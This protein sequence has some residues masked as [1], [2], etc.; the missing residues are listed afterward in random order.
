MYIYLTTNTIN[1]KKYIGMCTRDDD[2]YFGSGKLIKSAIKKYGKENFSKSILEECSSLEELSL[3][4]IKWIN[5]YD[6]VNSD[7]FYNLSLGGYGGNPETVKAYWDSLTK[8]ERS[9]RNKHQRGWNVKGE[10]NPMY[11][12]STS[13]QVKNV[14]AN[15]SKEEIDIIAQKVSATRKTRAVAVGRNNP[16]YGRSAVIENNL[17][18]YT[19]GEKNIYVTE[20]TQ[21]ENFKRGRTTKWSTKKK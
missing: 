11:G 17:K 9:E 4:E 7:D 20:G 16:M 1:G 3:A 18:W 14:W 21:P 13:V 6:A 10:N 15:R 5:Y 19:D 2:W 12:K 8:E